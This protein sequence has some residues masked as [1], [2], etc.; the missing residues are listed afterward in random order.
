M[1]LVLSIGSDPSLMLT[2]QLLLEQAGHTVIGVTDEKTLAAACELHTFD[3]AILSQI[4]SLNMKQHVVSLIRGHCPE[5][6]LLELY[7]IT[8]GRAL[9]DADLW[10]EVPGNGPEKLTAGVAELAAKRE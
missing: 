2:R 4:L 6:K 8:S 5:V 10:I 1:A 7:S 9:D 3:V